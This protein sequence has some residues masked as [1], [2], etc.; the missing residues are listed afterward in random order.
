[1]NWLKAVGYAIVIFAI[2]FV[3]ASILMFGLGFKMGEMPLSIAMVVIAVIVLWLAA[4]MYKLRSAGEGLQAGIVWMVV[5][6]V[7][8]FLIIVSIFNKGNLSFYTWSVILGYALE[9]A[10]PTYVGGMAK[11]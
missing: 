7:V 5:N 9:L 3:S 8:E 2:N 10:I 1:M 4:S 11:K 6:V